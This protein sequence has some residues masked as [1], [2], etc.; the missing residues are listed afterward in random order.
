MVRHYKPS[1]WRP[2]N[3]DFTGEAHEAVRQHYPSEVM[4]RIIKAARLGKLTSDI[5]RQT[6]LAGIIETRIVQLGVWTINTAHLVKRPTIAERKAALIKIEK[7]ALKL[8]QVLKNLDD[9]CSYDLRRAMLSDPYSYRALL[10]DPTLDAA[11]PLLGF[12]KYQTLINVSEK[13][14]EWASIAQAN[15]K[16]AKD[17]DKL[18]DP[19]RWFAEGLVKIWIAIGYKKPTI[20]YSSLRNPPKATGALME[21]V[22]LAA[23]PMGFKSMEATL[24]ESIDLWKM[25]KN[26]PTNLHSTPN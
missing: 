8:N 26:T 21:F 18:A 14:P 11:H 4:N 3:W 24:R 19:K 15:T 9:D 1:T 22:T 17:G 12:A 23:E 5:G 6:E 16:K 25:E 2:G 10:T 7:L 13:I 20:T